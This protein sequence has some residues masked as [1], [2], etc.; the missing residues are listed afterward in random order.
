MV[1]LI[2]KPTQHRYI[3]DYIYLEC[4]CVVNGLPGMFLNSTYQTELVLNI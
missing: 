2:L 3:C 1:A 4:D